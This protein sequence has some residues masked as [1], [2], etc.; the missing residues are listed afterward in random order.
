LLSNQERVVHVRQ[1][2]EPV[3]V[4]EKSPSGLTHVPKTPSPAEVKGP[5]NA[6]ALK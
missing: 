2:L 1:G 6:F 3:L 4:L 5:R